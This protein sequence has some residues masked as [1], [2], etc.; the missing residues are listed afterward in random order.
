[1]SKNRCGT[2]NYY[3]AVFYDSLALP[4]D[5][6]FKKFLEGNIDP[7]ITK[8]NQEQYN[9]LYINPQRDLWLPY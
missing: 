4:M 3:G 8:V 5:D 7:L 2:E 6:A 9:H 1:M